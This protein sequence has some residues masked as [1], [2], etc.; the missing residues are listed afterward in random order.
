MLENFSLSFFAF[1]YLSFTSFKI[2]LDRIVVIINFFLLIFMM[3]FI[4]N[5][6]LTYC[7]LLKGTHFPIEIK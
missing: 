4:V 7:P 3:L 6:H 1:N 5:I 2:L